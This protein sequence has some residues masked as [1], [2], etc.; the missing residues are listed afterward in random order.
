MSAA[1]FAAPPTQSQARSN[2]FLADIPSSYTR[3]VE[4]QHD[5]FP[6]TN[7]GAMSPWEVIEAALARKTPP[8]KVQWL[9]TKLDVS[10]QV[11]SNWK[12]RGVPPA[13]FRAIADALGLTVDQVEGIAPLPWA[14]D[15]GWPF[16]GIDPGRYTKLDTW[17]KGEIQG[18]V[19]EM[20]DR[21][22]QEAAPRSGK[23]SSSGHGG[24][25][26]AQA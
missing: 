7:N 19:K 24:P 11:V 21:F 6:D 18:K 20:L 2:G 16:P 26:S 12:T 25:K 3:S 1:S 4:S 23:S 15:D 9:A 5:V 17:Q 13:R 10:A 14:A 8:R 22:E